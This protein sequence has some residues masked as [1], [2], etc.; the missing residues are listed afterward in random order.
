MLIVNLTWFALF[1]GYYCYLPQGNRS[2]TLL[3]GPIQPLT[4]YITRSDL[5]TDVFLLLK[6]A[7]GQICPIFQLHVLIHGDF[8]QTVIL[9]WFQ[10]F[11][12][13]LHHSYFA[14]I[15]FFHFTAICHS[16]RSRSAKPTLLSQ[17]IIYVEIWHSTVLCHNNRASWCDVLKSIAI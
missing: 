13:P 3:S 17:E 16:S 1:R 12:A 8:C 10:S 14:L 5:W 6:Y 9:H 15:K 2:L 4:G 7:F 11:L